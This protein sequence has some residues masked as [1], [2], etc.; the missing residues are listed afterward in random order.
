M[1]L[2]LDSEGWTCRG[3]RV[4]VSGSGGW[5]RSQGRE[6]RIQALGQ[7]KKTVKGKQAVSS[8]SLLGLRL[9]EWEK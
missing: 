2:C 8:L 4:C 3:A 1:A 6:T 7:R 5:N 9:S